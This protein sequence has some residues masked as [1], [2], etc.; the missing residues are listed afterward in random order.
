MQTISL[1]SPP[2]CVRR[3]GR[4]RRRGRLC[5]AVRPDAAQRGS[6]MIV[7]E[8]DFNTILTKAATNLTIMSGRRFPPRAPLPQEGQSAPPLPRTSNAKQISKRTLVA[9]A[10]TGPL[11]S[12]VTLHPFD[13]ILRDVHPKQHA[14]EDGGLQ[15]LRSVE[16]PYSPTASAR[17][18]RQNGIRKP[19][20]SRP[21]Y[22][23]LRGRRCGG[24]GGRCATIPPLSW[25][26]ERQRYCCCNGSSEG[27]LCAS[28]PLRASNA[29]YYY[30]TTSFGEAGAPLAL[31]V[32]GKGSS[33]P[34][35]RLSLTIVEQVIPTARLWNWK[36][37]CLIPRPVA[38][39]RLL[40]FGRRCSE[41]SS[42]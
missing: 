1:F 12:L 31:F 23:R 39:S 19:R 33:T 34:Q 3:A 30:C 25:L 4:T 5:L 6:G 35:G 32:A 41:A 7:Y 14:S 24:E 28:P 11:S 8:A 20:K 10:F 17:T 38:T 42:C 40:S 36:A 27:S 22:S 29:R 21:D 18:F 2:V 16:A 15:N 9:F 13:T 37:Q 26:C